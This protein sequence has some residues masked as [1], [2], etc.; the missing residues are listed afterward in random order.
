MGV[1]GYADDLSLL[2]PSFSGMREMLNVCERNANDNTIL[3]NVSK[4]QILL[5]SK[6]KDSEN[7]RKPQLR[8]NNGQLIPY[9]KICIHLQYFKFY[10][11]GTCNDN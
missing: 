9:V 11:K 8:M 7:N 10:F 2:C 3:F 1:F 4:G 5:F 6:N